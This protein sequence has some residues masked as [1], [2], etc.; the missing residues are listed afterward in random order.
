MNTIIKY[1][2]LLLAIL[3]SSFVLSVVRADEVGS[4]P[5]PVASTPAVQPGERIAKAVTE[6]A[7]K[8]AQEFEERAATAIEAIANPTPSK[9]AR[10]W[11]QAA[12]DGLG[13]LVDGGR[14]AVCQAGRGIMNVDGAAAGL[15]RIPSQYV[16]EVAFSAA[17][18]CNAA[19][20]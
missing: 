9:P 8:Q 19:S 6:G 18:T 5:A 12:G 2:A 10:T 11:T 1:G 17:T 15:V 4:T 3:A 13:A 16:E 7:A 20:K 14:F